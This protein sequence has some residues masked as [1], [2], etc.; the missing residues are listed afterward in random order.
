MFKSRISYQKIWGKK[1][2]W[3]VGGG[4]NLPVTKH[5]RTSLNR[6]ESVSYK[7]AGENIFVKQN[8]LFTNKKSGRNL[9]IQIYDEMHITGHVWSIGG[10]KDL[11]AQLRS[12]KSHPDM[13]C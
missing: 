8:Y 1:N 11:Q 3:G 10:V 2:K 4:K 7:K 12:V 6:P 13:F 9:I 5:N